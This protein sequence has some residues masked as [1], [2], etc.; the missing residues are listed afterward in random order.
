M[1]P[2]GCRIR[3]RGLMS[4]LVQHFVLWECATVTPTSVCWLSYSKDVI[5]LMV[6]CVLYSVLRALCSVSPKCVVSITYALVKQ[7][8]FVYSFT[9]YISTSSLSAIF[10]RSL[11]LT[12]SISY[13]V[14]VQQVSFQPISRNI[15]RNKLPFY[16]IS[17]VIETYFPKGSSSLTDFSNLLKYFYKLFYITAF[18]KG[19]FIFRNIRTF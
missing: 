13:S 8:I 6:A 3:H 14:F 7:F 15:E 17:L 11:I 16:S 10:T 19:L 12:A 5:S 9:K 2:N 1:W 18:S 4:T